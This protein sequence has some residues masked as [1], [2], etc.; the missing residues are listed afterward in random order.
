[1]SW[2]VELDVDKGGARGILRVSGFGSEALAHRVGSAFLL[3]LVGMFP[4]PGLITRRVV[5]EDRGPGDAAHL[6]V[7]PV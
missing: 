6:P 7:P 3:A 5:E 4:G 1:M 2:R